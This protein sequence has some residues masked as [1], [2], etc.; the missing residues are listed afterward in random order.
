MAY[1]GSAPAPTAGVF[2]NVY[3]QSFSGN[4]STTTFTLGRPVGQVANIEVLVNNVQQSPF[5]SSYTLSGGT[6][7]VFSEAPSTGTNNIYVIYRDYPVQTLTDTGAVR[8]TGGDTIT[9]RLT[10]TTSGA[11]GLVLDTDTADSTT[12]SR[13][14]LKNNTNAGAIYYE[15]TTGWAFNTGSTVLSTSGTKRFAIDTSGRVTKPYQPS[16]QAS[17]AISQANQTAFTSDSEVLQFGSTIHNIG[18][19][20]NTSTYRFTA[21]VSAR[22]IFCCTARFDGI[23]AGSYTRLYFTVNNSPNSYT[24]GHSISG[25]N[26]SVDYETTT[27]SALINLNAG[28]YVQVLGGRNGGGGSLQFES[29]FSGMLIG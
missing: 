5:D 1:L 10:V 17:R 21:P 14:F 28:D 26:H 4:G 24:Y 29:Q 20:Y 22:Y 16:F 3:S 13:L 18:G 7:L 12:S 6:S 2:S 25:N 8:K 11:D 27:I 19:H 15:S 23:T 9:G